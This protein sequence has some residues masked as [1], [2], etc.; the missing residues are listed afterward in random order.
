MMENFQQPFI[1]A[2]VIWSLKNK[3]TTIINKQTLFIIFIYA[4]I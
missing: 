1:Q 2:S 4:C 3:N